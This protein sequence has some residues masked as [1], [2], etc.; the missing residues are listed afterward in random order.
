ACDPR[1]ARMRAPA[2]AGS[3]RLLGGCDNLA[4]VLWRTRDEC[5]RRHARLVAA[6]RDGCAG[7]VAD[8][9]AEPG[10]DGTVRAVLDRGDG[11]RTGLSRLGYGELRY[12]ALALVLLTGPGVL[13]VDPAGEVP[14]ALQTLTVLADG[15]DRGLD[16]RQR[17]ALLDL[18]AAMCARGHIRLV[19]AVADGSWAAGA[20]GVTVVHLEP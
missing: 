1:P 12:L 5:G 17:R 13:A 20:A 14:P 4:D 9:L 8:V 7:P 11:L 18:A 19:G 6:V 10:R 15:F 2:R 16:P 3:G